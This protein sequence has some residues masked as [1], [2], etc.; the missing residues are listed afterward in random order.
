VRGIGEPLT[1]G[2]ELKVAY[3]VNRGGGGGMVEE[4]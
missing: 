3:G 1:G 2:D 4:G